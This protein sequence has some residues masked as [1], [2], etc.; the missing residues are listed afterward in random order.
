MKGSRFTYRYI[1]IKNYLMEHHIYISDF[2]KFVNAVFCNTDRQKIHNLTYQVVEKSMA[3]NVIIVFDNILSGYYLHN[4]VKNDIDI[5]A[6]IYYLT[7]IR[8][9]MTHRRFH[10]MLQM[11]KIDAHYSENNIENVIN[12]QMIYDSAM[13]WIKCMNHGNEKITGKVDNTSNLIFTL[14]IVDPS[15]RF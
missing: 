7:L 5:L 12:M 6:K 13:D 10:I 15:V 14:T 4:N 11:C 1:F 3:Q 9:S 2:I 8:L